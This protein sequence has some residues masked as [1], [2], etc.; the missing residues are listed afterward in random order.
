MAQHRFDVDPW[1]IG[2]S[3][4]RDAGWEEDGQSHRESV[5]ALSNG[6]IGWRG[7][8]DEGDPSAA[9]G[10]YLNGVFE[11]HPMP[12]AE[13]GYGYPE[14]GQTVV[15]VPDGK[16]IRL[17]VDDEPFDIRTGELISHEQ[18]LDFRT[19]ILRRT[20]VW[21]SPAGRRVTVGSER[22]VSF[23][24]RSIAAVRY[25]VTSIDAEVEVTLLSEIVADEPLPEVHPDPRVME[26]L[27]HPF[28]PV[29]QR[30]SAGRAT[31]TQRT[32]RSGITV[33]VATDHRIEASAPQTVEPR[34]EVGH[35]LARTTVRARLAPGESVRLFKAV[36]H[37]WSSDV[38]HVAL[39]DRAETAVSGAIDAGW[40]ALV[41]E[42]SA[43]LDDFWARADIVIEGDERLQQSV[44]FALFQ[45]VQAAAR[46]EVRSIPGKGLTGVG[47]EGHTFWD[48]EAFVLPVLTYTQPRAARDA[49]VWR[50]STLD[51]ARH[52]AEQLHLEGAAFPWRTIDGRECSGYW[53]AGTIAFH[54]NADIAAA[55]TRYVRATGDEEFEREKG[56]ELLVETARLWCSLGRWDDDGSFHIDGVTGP[57]EYSALV[58]DNVFTNLMAQR[59]LRAAA[60]TSQRYGDEASALGVTSDEIARWTTTADAVSIPYDADLGIPQQSAGF[61]QKQRWDFEATGDEQYPLHSHFPYFDLYRKQVIKQ[62]DLVLALQSTPEAFSPDETARA[63]AYYDELTVRDSSL[64]ASV[65]AVVAARTGHLDLAMDYLVEAGTIDLDDLRDDVDEGL[66]VAALAGV[67][68][69]LVRGFGGMRDDDER[70]RFAPRV[71]APMRAFSFGM[72]VRGRALRVDV[73]HDGV[74]YRLMDGPP[75]GIR[76][77]DEE[78]TL[79]AGATQRLGIPPLPDPGPRP[80]QPRGRAPRRARTAT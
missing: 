66:H 77:F 76:H 55:V 41:A 9:A 27:R 2:W 37:E 28:E 75:L 48:A 40:E 47:Y 52:R 23:T 50:H 1:A 15:H 49:L 45:V 58:D 51:H 14:H 56:L 20:A 74:T 29:E 59:N 54:I 10:S 12:Y 36:G 71:A 13:D 31:M 16:V 39:Q 34:T 79:E 63:F 42:Q 4:L 3:C 68:N 72:L 70:L 62:A 64:S 38:E 24:R 69:A 33:A 44:R 30:A 43:Y 22:V 25:E 18:H 60:E 11:E 21:R 8:L 5:L 67:W 61:T 46:A 19:G 26:A 65:Q 32:R 7:T 6:H 35:D 53:P 73:E 80:T 57:D 78:I 17:L